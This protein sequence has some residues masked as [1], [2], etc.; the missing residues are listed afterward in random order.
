MRTGDG[1]LARLPPLNRPMTPSMLAAL[2]S[3]AERHGNGLV[4]ISKRGNLQLRGLAETGAGPLAADLAAAGFDLDEGIPISIDPLAS[5][6]GIDAAAIVHE[7]HRRIQD[8]GL[9]KNLAPKFT[10][11][12]DLGSPLAPQGLS[13]DLRL[14]FRTGRV[15]IGLGGGDAREANWIGWVAAERAVDAA[16][17]LL[18]ALATRGPGVR[19]RGPGGL[20]DEPAMAAAVGGLSD[21]SFAPSIAATAAAIGPIKGYDVAVQGIAFPF[22][23]SD[24]VALHELAAAASRCGL[25]A[26][27][28]APERTLLLAGSPEAVAATLA[29]AARLGFVTEASDPRRFIAACI[30]SE[31]CASGRIPARLMADTAAAALAPLLDGSFT[32]HLSGCAKGCAHPEP[33]K[34]ALV[35]VDNGAGLVLDGL[36]RDAP[37]GIAPGSRLLGGLGRLAA[38]AATKLPGTSARAAL[39]SMERAGILGAMTGETAGDDDDRGESRDEPRDARLSA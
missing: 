10:I 27:A 8:A 17:A 37:L 3:A 30:G 9:S 31:G 20:A 21:V 38:M 7:L 6:A 29:V 34:I 1:W 26:F 12:L 5:I 23:Q 2:A 15:A 35:G 32:L 36:A 16:L 22:G 14:A 33:A 24:A 25:A 4:E 18:E 39:D 19:L 13:A 28:P 11:V